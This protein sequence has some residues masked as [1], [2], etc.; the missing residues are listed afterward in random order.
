MLGSDLSAAMSRGLG[1]APGDSHQ[2]RLLPVSCFRPRASLVGLCSTLFLRLQWQLLVWD[3]ATG[4]HKQS[5][6]VAARHK[7]GSGLGG[8]EHRA[9]LLM[10]SESARERQRG[11]RG[12]RAPR[13]CSPSRAQ[14]AGNGWPEAPTHPEG[15]GG[16]AQ[17]LGPNGR[18]TPPW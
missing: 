18:G 14:R 17:L 2:V 11:Q 8:S 10:L 7:G 13:P 1:R 12:R 16:P 6:W 5:Q 9:P 4:R 15:S 3:S